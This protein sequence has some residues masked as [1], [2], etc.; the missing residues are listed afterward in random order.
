MFAFVISLLQ[1]LYPQIHLSLVLLNHKII[2]HITLKQKNISGFI[3][4]VNQVYYTITWQE[5]MLRVDICIWNMALEIIKYVKPVSTSGEV[6]FVIQ[7]A[8]HTIKNYTLKS[9]CK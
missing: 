3:I 8:P 6:T 1:L 2:I 4:L 7:T 9:V 5:E